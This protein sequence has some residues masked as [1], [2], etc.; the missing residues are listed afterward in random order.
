ME[1]LIKY[2]SRKIYLT[3][4]YLHIAMITY[5]HEIVVPWVVDNQLLQRGMAERL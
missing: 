1:E 4:K 5:M 2:P 3:L